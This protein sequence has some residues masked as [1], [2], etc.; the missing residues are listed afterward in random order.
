MLRPSRLFGAFSQSGGKAIQPPN[1]AVEFP[2]DPYRTV[3]KHLPYHHTLLQATQ[4]QPVAGFSRSTNRYRRHS[5]FLHLISPLECSCTPNQNRTYTV[6]HSSSDGAP[7]TSS[8]LPVFLIQQPRSLI[9]IVS[10]PSILSYALAAS[11]TVGGALSQTFT[12]CN[13]LNSTCP[14][15]TALGT[16]AQ[17]DF[18]TNEASTSVWNTS[19]TPI[20]YNTKGAQYTIKQHGDAP[21][22]TAQFY[23]FWGSV[24]V[25]MKAAS[26]TGICSS[27]VLLSDDLDEIDWEVR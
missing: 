1:S 9:L 25:V 5:F 10:M 4:Q 7:Y 12:S 15:D 16:Y 8:H 6:A 21:T 27:I 20:G 14:A 19:Y 23:I 3:C 17:F 22:L 26:G 11:L 13:P 24:S 2:H 18:S